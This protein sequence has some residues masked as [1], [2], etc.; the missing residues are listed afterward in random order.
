M[1]RAKDYDGEFS[2]TEQL[3]GW[4]LAVGMAGLFIA[5]LLWVDA[6]ND[7]RLEMAAAETRNVV[8]AWRMDGPP[9]WLTL[10]VGAVPFY[11]V[12][13]LFGVRNWRLHPTLGRKA[14]GRVLTL[15]VL[16]LAGAT[17]AVA[18]FSGH[19]RGI[20]TID[21]VVWLKNREVIARAPWSAATGVALNCVEHGRS[22]RLKL[23]YVVTFAG[24]RRVDLSPDWGEP[25][26]HW[27]ERLE[28]APILH[29]V[30]HGAVSR[31]ELSACVRLYARR[32][33]EE[34]RRRLDG[35]L[36]LRADNPDYV[37]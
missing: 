32:L 24:G 35:V 12:P 31:G 10:L 25:A 20:A 30:P 26:L 8:A 14:R 15:L 5:A 16:V 36:G 18:V 9:P 11:F 27:I 22:K 3:L 34:D 37:G 23:A 21:E 33:D 6:R 7:M 28:D 13:G 4:A 1:I 19:R 29:V 2:L 17:A